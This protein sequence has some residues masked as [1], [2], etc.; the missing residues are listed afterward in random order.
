ML[1][2]H[3]AATVATAVVLS[4]AERVLWWVVSLLRPRLGQRFDGVVVSHVA[5]QRPL[6]PL[7]FRRTR[8]LGGRAPPLLA[9]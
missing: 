2:L 1:A 8:P 3:A 5:P 6:L 4:R 7:P 9:A